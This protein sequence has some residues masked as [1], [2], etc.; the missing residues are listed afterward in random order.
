MKLPDVYTDWR[1]M[2][3]LALIVLGAV[4]WVVGLDRTQE[5]SRIVART[6]DVAADEAYRSFD[7]LDPRT[8]GAVLAPFTTEQRRVSYATARMDFYHA[9]FLT[10]QALVL[11]GVVL[12]LVGFIVIIQRDS[13]HANRR[14]RARPSGPA[15]PP[16]S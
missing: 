10:G 5:Y 9:T 16:E 2:A 12:T 4:N 8:D 6:P 3:G 14:L 7:E 11:A 15:P 1:I 13:R